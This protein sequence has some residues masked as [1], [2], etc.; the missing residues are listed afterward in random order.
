MSF[1]NVHKQVMTTLHPLHPCWLSAGSVLATLA[2]LQR[3]LE[4]KLYSAY[5]ALSLM[6][7]SHIIA[8]ESGAAAFTSSHLFLIFP[9]VYF[10]IEPRRG[11]CGSSLHYAAGCRWGKW[12]R[13]STGK[14]DLGLT[15][16]IPTGETKVS[17]K[18]ELEGINYSEQL[19]NDC[20]WAGEVSGVEWREGGCCC[21]S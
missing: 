1:D 16:V 17:R 18:C 21:W 10:L 12:R 11:H 3:H 15:H 19:K 8:G 14:T 6:W 9:Q 4:V 20:H 2:R 7:W 5:G 13:E